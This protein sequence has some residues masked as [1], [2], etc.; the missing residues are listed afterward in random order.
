MRLSSFG[1]LT[2]LDFQAFLLQQTEM[3][4]KL[5]RLWN[6]LLKLIPVSYPSRDKSFN[7]DNLV[8]VARQSTVGGNF[9]YVHQIEHFKSTLN[10]ADR[11]SVKS[12]PLRGI[13]SAILGPGTATKVASSSAGITL[14]T[15]THLSTEIMSVWFQVSNYT[16]W[17]SKEHQFYNR[18]KLTF[19]LISTFLLNYLWFTVK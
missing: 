3:G 17:L 18:E 10:Y 5:M 1:A 19:N 12:R 9:D 6:I 7:W 16:V 15:S 8:Y 4:H 11:L 13:S 2:A 14:L